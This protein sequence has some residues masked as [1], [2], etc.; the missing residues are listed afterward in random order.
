[1]M[2]KKLTPRFGPRGS[3][4][5]SPVFVEPGLDTPAPT[6]KLAAPRPD[7]EAAS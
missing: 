1:M 4:T 6:K 5:K 7:T 2:Q 3:A